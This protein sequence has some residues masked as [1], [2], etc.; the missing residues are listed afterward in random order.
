ML[1]EKDIIHENG[2]FWVIKDKAGFHVMKSGITH[3]TSD[4]SYSS[5]DLAI[6]RCNYLAKHS[7]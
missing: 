1:K 4:S 5:L 7:A 6:A 3:S 2:I